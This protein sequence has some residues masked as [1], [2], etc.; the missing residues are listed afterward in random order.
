MKNLF[1]F[2]TGYMKVCIRDGQTERFLNLCMA[3]G[4]VLWSLT[5]NP[6]K[7]LTFYI[8]VRH[9]LL[10]APVRRKTGVKIH[11]L[12]KHGLPFFFAYS[13]KRKAFFLGLLIFGLLLFLFS[14]RIWNI[15]IEGNLINST[16][17]ILQFLEKEGISHG[18][19]KAS[20]NCSSLAARIREKY[21]ETAWVSVE[22]QGTRLL[23]TIKEGLFSDKKQIS[24]KAPCSIAAGEDGVIESMVTR[25]GMPLTEPGKVCKKGDIL[26][27]GRLDLHNDSQ[28]VYEYQ[29]VHADADI[30]IRRKVSYYAELPLKYEK[31]VSGKKEKNGI[32]IKAGSLYLEWG[33][34]LGKDW[35][36]TTEERP[37]RITENF[38]LPFSFGKITDKK[39]KKQELLRSE[40]EAKA[41][42]FHILQQYEEKLM[43]KG[44]QIFSN[45]VKIEVDHFTCISRGT[46]EIIEKTGT[47]VPVEKLEQPILNSERTTE[48]G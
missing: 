13:R 8:T 42:A 37:L 19:A 3:R 17:E 23:I 32:Y 36:R 39:Y 47:E 18:I 44:V 28:E 46:L 41:A 30:Y 24:D 29:Y 31:S 27:L 21:P 5:G 2:L 9:F 38:I 11:I 20:V 1:S 43:E 6:E 10:L 45:N 34:K 33:K 48:N 4:I 7:E 26:V 40:Q 22:I 14:G 15:H 35:Y 25:A 16:P 12:E